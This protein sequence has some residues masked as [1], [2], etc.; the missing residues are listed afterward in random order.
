VKRRK[1]L[2]QIGLGLS[3][4]LAMPHFLTSCAK[5]DPGPEVPFD[6]NVVII[7]AGAAGLF[8]ADILNSKGIKV[9]VLEASNQLG[10]RIQSFRNSNET[11]DSLL[12]DTKN[13]TI[14]DFPV[15]LGAELVFGTD[16]SMGKI[17]SNLN[18]TT[19]ILDNA[20]ANRFIIDNKVMAAVDLQGDA[21][22]VAS[23][24]FVKAL[25]NY[26]GPSVSVKQAAGSS[27]R[28]ESI[29]DAQIGNYYGTSNDKLGITLLS[30]D[31]KT[32]S[33][34]GKVFTMKA[35]PMQD[36]LISRFSDIQPL[37]EMGKQVVA[38][39]YGSD[40]IV[41]TLK[42]GST[43]Q[44]NKVILTVPISILKGGGISFSPGL[45]GEMTSAL[46]RMG[47]DPTL[48]LILDFK[49]NFWG[50]NS[51]FILGGKT[52]PQYFNAGVSKSEFYRTMSITINGAKAA[53]LSAKGPDLMIADILAELDALYAGQGS[54]YIRRNLDAADPNFGKIIYILK[55]WSKDPF[56][57]GG[58]SYPL[59]NATAT[60]RLA[61]GKPVNN[62]LFFAGEATDIKGDAGTVSGALSSAERVSE[63]VIKSILGIS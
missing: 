35:N 5:D 3:A 61:I 29:L 62:K 51:D 36:V 48:R 52:A 1:V 11:T 42:D 8:T 7:G 19:V 34:D 55:D 56:T 24:N 26:V 10:G 41:I 32:R 13:R 12:F 15:E 4:G 53:A 39:N 58:Y 21:D 47:M 9:S 30:Q 22:F 23:Q 49:K 63:E 43:V 44:A 20:A 18:L 57:K 2:K 46:S 6:G 54:L 37:V 14:A 40:P 17:V 59:A 50:E 38:I 28:T 16:S 25:P 60:D 45:P 27:I 33:H 31:L